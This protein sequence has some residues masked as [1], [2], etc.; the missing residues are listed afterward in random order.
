MNC[1]WLRINEIIFF[2]KYK[3]NN[4]VNTTLLH[5]VMFGELNI[6]F[7]P[8]KKKTFILCWPK[9]QNKN[10]YLL[11]LLFLPYWLKK[12]GGSFVFFLSVSG[13]LKFSGGNKKKV[14]PFTPFP[15]F[16]SSTNHAPEEFRVWNSLRC[17]PY[18][19]FFFNFP[20]FCSVIWSVAGYVNQVYFS[21]LWRKYIKK[22]VLD[23]KLRRFR[24][25]LCQG[26]ILTWWVCFPFVQKLWRACSFLKFVVFIFG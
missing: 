2:P 7:F 25:S 1:L 5:C 18:S 8:P 26:R 20:K 6:L 4:E 12:K 17:R 16:F 22:C 19:I 24:S 9:F 10:F 3:W 15:L 14:Y 23:S 21:G 11:F 13:V